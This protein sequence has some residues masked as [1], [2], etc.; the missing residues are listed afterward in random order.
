VWKTGPHGPKWLKTKPK[1]HLTPVPS[2]WYTFSMP[3]LKQEKKNSRTRSRGFR[4]THTQYI[5]LSAPSFKERASPL[6]RVLLNLYFNK[7]LN[8][9]DIEDLITQE[10]AKSSAAELEGQDKIRVFNE[11]KRRGA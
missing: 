9:S 4:I 6:I 10:A 7:K 3:A 2:R 1:K 8:V 5:L 11:N